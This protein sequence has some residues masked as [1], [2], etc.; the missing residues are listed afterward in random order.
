MVHPIEEDVFRALVKK[1][2]VPRFLLFDTTNFVVEHPAGRLPARGPSKEKRYDKPLVG[3]GLVTV[4]DLP[5]LTEVYPGNQGDAKVFA[6]VFGTLAK[7]LIDL[8]V[9]TQRLSWSSTG[10]SIRPTI[11]TRSGG[12]CRSSRP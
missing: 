10:E 2:T 7:R 5:V 8:E 3:L 9:A 11:S 12:R 4:G 6:E 1:G